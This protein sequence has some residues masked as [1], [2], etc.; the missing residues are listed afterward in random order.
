MGTLLGR[1]WQATIAR[2]DVIVVQAWYAPTMRRVIRRAEHYAPAPGDRV[3]VQR[4]RWTGPAH[5]WVY[6]T[7]RVGERQPDGTLTWTKAAPAPSQVPE[8][9]PPG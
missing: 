7:H 5:G 6:F 1:R 3:S 8:P 4:R 9:D 2:Q